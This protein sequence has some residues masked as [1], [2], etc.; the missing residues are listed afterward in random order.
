METEQDAA[1][2]PKP[3]LDWTEA[4]AGQLDWHWRQQLRPRLAGLSD[5]EYFWEPVPACLS[6]RPFG[7]SRAPATA[8]TGQFVM[9][10]VAPGTDPPPVTTIAWR[11]AHITVGCLAAPAARH[12]GGPPAD[13]GSFEYAGT[14]VRALEQLDD[15]YAAWI[16]GVRGLGADG[17]A[18]PCGPAYGPYADEPMSAL[19]LHYNREII[20]HGAEI[21]LLRDLYQWRTRNEAGR[22]GL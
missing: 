12:F 17:L 8:G 15:A 11:L 18:S 5:D 7:A 1:G 16:H 4:L 9:E 22:N 21:A 2:H 3:D 14:A 13:F 6:I 19:I 20:H 10:D